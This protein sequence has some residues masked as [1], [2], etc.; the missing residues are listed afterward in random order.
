MPGAHAWG[1]KTFQALLVPLPS[2]W[3]HLLDVPHHSLCL[4]AISVLHGLR[5]G[6]E[7]GSVKGILKCPKPPPNLPSWGTV[8]FLMRFFDVHS[9]TR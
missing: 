2:Q 9:H 8:T 1:L 4:K 3:E 6:Q 5:A 7:V